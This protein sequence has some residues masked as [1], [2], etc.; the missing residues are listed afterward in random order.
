MFTYINYK[1]TFS[2]SWNWYLLAFICVQYERAN[3]GGNRTI[4]WRST[5][6]VKGSRQSMDTQHCLLVYSTS[7]HNCCTTTGGFETDR[8]MSEAHTIL[9][10]QPHMCTTKVQLFWWFAISICQWA[11]ISTR[12]YR[13]RISRP[14]HCT[15]CKNY[16]QISSNYQCVPLCHREHLLASTGNGC[17]EEN[18]HATRTESLLYDAECWR[19]T[20]L[21]STRCA[22]RRPVVY[23]AASDPS[24]V[25][26][27]VFKLVAY[28]EVSNH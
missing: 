22:R 26:R 14:V 3:I 23:V 10:D 20:V 19:K 13:F 12:R 21:P 25:T 1:L 16:A 18:T 5:A 17:W 11:L 2:C 24:P 6:C 28:K 7:W 9:F 8:T 27:D 4:T 15:R